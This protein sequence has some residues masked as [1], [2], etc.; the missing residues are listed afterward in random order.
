MGSKLKKLAVLLVLLVSLTAC[1][2]PGVGTYSATQTATLLS[3]ALPTAE[4]QLAVTDGQFCYAI[5]LQGTSVGADQ[6][7]GGYENTRKN[8]IE[9]LDRQAVINF[10]TAHCAADLASTT[11]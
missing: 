9:H 3:S 1:E 10:L 5:T 8:P 11:V 6:L 2:S 4:A 7:I